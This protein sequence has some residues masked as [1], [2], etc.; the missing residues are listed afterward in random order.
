[1]SITKHK[2]F[3]IF[4]DGT[5]FLSQIAR[6]F[7][8]KYDG[9]KPPFSAL[10]AATAFINHISNEMV[11]N[12]AYGLDIPVR[13][14]WFGS[15]KGDENYEYDLKKY[16]RGKSYEAVLFKA[17]NNKEKGVDIALT[18]EML[19]NA[20]NQN[21]DVGLVIAGDEDYVELINDVK[22]FGIHVRGAFFAGKGLSKKLQI[23]YD[24]Y[25]EMG[26]F[27]WIKTQYA[28]FAKAIEYE[29]KEYKKMKQAKKT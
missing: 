10:D 29:Q 26:D 17:I 7:D 8:I 16:L 2:K 13:K 4:V 3:M 21:Y 14:F 25:F 5:N 22:R 28:E 15:Y 6:E 24:Q 27:Q 11:K 12:A 1:M 20:F 23:T 9:Q 18:R 19:L